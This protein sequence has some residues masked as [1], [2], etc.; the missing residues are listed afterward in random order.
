MFVLELMYTA[1][2]EQ[3]DEAL[4]RHA[5]W[6]RGQFEAGAFLAAGRK[7]PREGGV[8]LVAGAD[9]AAVEA[10][11]ATDPFVREGLTEY[12]ITEFVATVTAPALEGYR[13]RL[14]A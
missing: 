13:E 4:P 3:I 7:V 1:P 6:L 12:R 5:E 14:P 8:I 9:R 10:L 2:L 11:V